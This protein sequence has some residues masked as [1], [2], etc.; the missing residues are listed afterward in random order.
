MKKHIVVIPD[1]RNWAWDNHCDGIIA[2]LS[3]V[4]DFTKM[5]LNDTKTEP[6]P[7]ADLYYWPS[8]NMKYGLTSR[9]DR[10]VCSIAGFHGA[11]MDDIHAALKKVRAAACYSKKMYEHIRN[12][13]DVPLM[14]A[15]HA[16]DV[17]KFKPVRKPEGEFLIVGW[18]G[19]PVKKRGFSDK[20]F[21]VIQRVVGSIPG[22]VLSTRVNQRGPYAEVI[23]FYQGLDVYVCYSTEEGF[24]M[25]LMEASACGVP[26]ITTRV[27]CAEEIDGATFVVSESDLKREV[28]W[29]RDN[30]KMTRQIGR[31]V[32]GSIMDTFSWD[33][34][35]H[36][37]EHFFEANMKGAA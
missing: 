18:T 12:D 30:R 8:Y 20:R 7:E 16:V 26:I 32:R 11:N 25:P 23:P 10:T 37:Y 9:K 3:D 19:Q 6:L 13:V 24:G 29:C 31:H 14:Y 4:Y 34:V 33:V 27:G 15:P 2:N 17:S 1:K 36:T 22:V 21:D 5:Y 28:E 35:K